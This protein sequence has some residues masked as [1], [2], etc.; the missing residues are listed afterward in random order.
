LAFAFAVVALALPPPASAAPPGVASR[1]ATPPGGTPPRAVWPLSPRPEIVRGFE[2]PPKPWLPGHRGLD[3]A[4]SPG[5]PVLAATAGTITYAGPLAGRGVVVVTSGPFR[6]TYEPVIPSTHVGATVTP[7]EQLGTLS[8]AGTHCPPRT[9]LHWGLRQATNYLNPLSLLGSSPV[10]LLPLT[11]AAP[12]K[13]STP[14]NQ[15]TEARRSEPA[16]GGVDHPANTADSPAGGVDHPADT[17]G[18]PATDVDHAAGAVDRA[19]PTSPSGVRSSP[20]DRNTGPV[21]AIVV[22]VSAALTLGCA[23]LIRRH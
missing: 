5:Q 22:G 11:P 18:S 1:R 16:T 6:T 15:L 17:A 12:L 8:A 19:A 14:A 21:P 3:L 4:G 9:C 10:R 20:A 2:P 23:L 7:G 13:R